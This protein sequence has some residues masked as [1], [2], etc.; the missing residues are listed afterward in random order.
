MRLQ[1]P[2]LVVLISLSLLAVACSGQ[3]ITYRGQNGK[4][5]VRLQTEQPKD[6]K[7]DSGYD[8]NLLIP[9]WNLETNKWGYIRRDSKELVVPHRFSY[10]ARYA[11]GFALAI[12]L[13]ADGIAEDVYRIDS[14]GNT[15]LIIRDTVSMGR[16]WYID[17]NRLLDDFCL[18]RLG[19]R[20]IAYDPQGILVMDSIIMDLDRR[21]EYSR[22]GRYTL[23]S[24]GKLL[25]REFGIGTIAQWDTALYQIERNVITMDTERPRSPFWQ[26]RNMQMGKVGILDNQ[27]K[28]VVPMIWDRKEMGPKVGLDVSNQF[29]Y[30]PCSDS[31][32]LGFIDEHFVLMHLNGK[33]IY[34][35]NDLVRPSARVHHAWRQQEL[36]SVTYFREYDGW[37]NALLDPKSDSIRS[38]CH[39]DIELI[40]A[41]NVLVVDRINPVSIQNFK[42]EQ[43]KILP[44]SEEY[45]IA[46]LRD[47]IHEGGKM[48]WILSYAIE[49]SVGAIDQLGELV[50][51]FEETTITALDFYQQRY[52]T[53]HAVFQDLPVYTHAF[54]SVE[55]KQLFGGRFYERHLGDPREGEVSKGSPRLDGPIL[56]PNSG[57][58]ESDDEGYK[59]HSCYLH[60]YAIEGD[61]HP[62]MLLYIDL[63]LNAG[64]VSKGYVDIYGYRY[65]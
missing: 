48:T 18:F 15:N 21:F 50:I 47:G 5:Y 56:H 22:D 39:C 62:N 52:H 45:P 28:L 44:Y 1:L 55:G 20:M 49:H 43:R 3:K 32:F 25:F 53:L 33:V 64:Q 23:Y 11:R 61:F 26:I 2:T 38:Y 58:A 6:I 60:P 29:L 37:N 63:Q 7:V 65:F 36:L 9:H 10:A 46:I 41:D 12:E 51:P 31:L 19:D 27:G 16:K 4:V 57:I 13:G 42:T 54:Y 17:K 59:M 34:S 40:A 35:Y 24:N 14:L 8:P 30:N